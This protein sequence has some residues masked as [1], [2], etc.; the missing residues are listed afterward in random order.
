MTTG[1]ELLAAASEECSD[2]YESKCLLRTAVIEL[3]I[4]TIIPPPC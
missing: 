2:S 4:K 1:K 3:C